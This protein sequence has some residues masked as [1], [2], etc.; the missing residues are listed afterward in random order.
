MKT[1]SQFLLLIFFW[2]SI[3]SLFGLSL[4]V[5][6]SGGIYDPGQLLDSEFVQDIEYRIRYEAEHRHF[7]IFVIIFDEEPSQGARILARQAGES[8]SQGEYWGVVYQVGADAEPDCIVGGALVS[9]LPAET[10]EKSVRGARNTALLVRTPQQRLEEMVSNLSDN[11]GFLYIQASQGHDAA[12]KAFDAK[13]E[14]ERKRKET[15][16]AWAIFSVIA[17]IGLSVVGFLVWK[18]HLRK[19]KPMEFPL[20]SPRRRLAAPFSGGGDVL[21]K[22]GKKH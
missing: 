13:R 20:T 16:R 11:F 22:F 1:S 19:L 6:P 17:L 2:A 15:L 7:E 12:V 4:K 3:S 18:K 5:R 21:V 8:W 14:A 9:Q 10:V